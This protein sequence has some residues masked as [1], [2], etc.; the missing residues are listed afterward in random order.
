MFHYILSDQPSM[1]GVE[2]ASHAHSLAGP[3]QYQA[4]GLGTR[5]HYV[6]CT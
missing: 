6:P 2:G 5:L 3:P 4:E 1:G